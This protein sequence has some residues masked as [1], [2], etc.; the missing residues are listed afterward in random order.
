ML[1]PPVGSTRRLAQQTWTTACRWKTA[2]R[3]REKG[4]IG[5]ASQRWQHAAASGKPA[6]ESGRAASGGG[7]RALRNGLWYALSGLACTAV[8]AYGSWHTMRSRGLGFY[9]DE[10]SLRRFT[11][12]ESDA[13]ALRIQDTIEKH[14][15]VAQLRQR[16]D[17]TESRPHLKMPG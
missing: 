8:G 3:W 12:A 7:G 10:E 16:P 13:E 14:P 6:H 4:P 15:L 11:P 1:S 9:S 5:R 17:L 2:P